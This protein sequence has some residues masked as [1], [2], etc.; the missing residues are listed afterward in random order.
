[1][2]DIVLIPEVADINVFCSMAEKINFF[3]FDFR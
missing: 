2:N 1:M 3:D